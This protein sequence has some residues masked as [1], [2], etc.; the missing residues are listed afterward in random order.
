MGSALIVLSACGQ[1]GPSANELVPGQAEYLRWC[2][3]CHGNAGEGKAPAFPPLA[4]SQWLDLPDRALALIVVRGLRG[5]IEVAGRAYRGYMPPMRHLNDQ[6]IA[7]I[8]HFVIASWGGREAQLTPAQVAE[9]R[10]LSADPP[11]PLDGLNG[12]MD[13]YERLP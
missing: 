4:G 3:S 7:S 10:L 1:T 11:V 5:E 8:L 2:A 13:A 6:D 9:L 12:V